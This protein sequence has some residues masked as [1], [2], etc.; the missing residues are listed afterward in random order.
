MVY[1][2]LDDY[3]KLKEVKVAKGMRGELQHGNQTQIE[4]ER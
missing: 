3:K 2:D 4:F 1:V